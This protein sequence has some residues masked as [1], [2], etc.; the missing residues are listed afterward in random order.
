MAIR[1]YLYLVAATP[2]LFC[3]SAV[4]I[5]T[6]WRSDAPSTNWH[7]PLNWTNGIPSIAGD[8]AT[9]STTGATLR[10]DLGQPASIAV[11]TVAGRGT[12]EISG[13]APLTFSDPSPRTQPSVSLIAQNGD[14][15][16]KIS[17]PLVLPTGEVLTI[18]QAGYSSLWLTGG[19][20]GNGAL[21]FSGRPT[22]YGIT[23]INGNSTYT[24][25]TTIDV[26]TYHTMQAVTSTAFGDDSVGTLIRNGW[27]STP[28]TT[29]PFVVEQFGILLTTTSTT[30]HAGKITLVGG[31]FVPYASNGS[32]NVASNIEIAGRGYVGRSPNASSAALFTGAITGAGTLVVEGSISNQYEFAGGVAVRGDVVL[33]DR[34]NA[35]FTGQFAPRG[36]LSAPGRNGLERARL[37]GD[38]S[39]FSGTVETGLTSLTIGSDLHTPRLRVDARSPEIRESLQRGGILIEAGKTANVDAL[40]F[41]AGSIEGRITGVDAIEKR[42]RGIGAVR[43]LDGFDGQISV[44]QGWLEIEDALGLGT[45]VG[46]TSIARSR[47]A[48]IFLEAGVRVEDALYLN[49]SSGMDYAGSIVGSGELAGN[50]YLGDQGSYVGGSENEASGSVTRTGHLTISGAIH[51]GSLSKMGMNTELR[52]TNQ[53]HTYSG[54]TRI[55]DGKLV[56]TENARLATTASIAVSGDVSNS[57]AD[58]RATL[59][60][61]DRGAVRSNDRLSD[62]VPVYLQSGR[63]ELLGSTAGGSRETI[64]AVHAE[65]GFNR[66]LATAGVIQI[67]EL[68]RSRGAV[69]SFGKPEGGAI[70][71]DAP[72]QNSLIGGWA[73]MAGGHSLMSSDAFATIVDGKVEAA[74]MTRKQLDLAAAHENIELASAMALTGDRTVNS[75]RTVGTVPIAL[76]N[77]TL[78]VESGGFIVNAETTISS[79]R[80]TAGAGS[81]HELFFHLGNNL[82]VAADIVDDGANPV[83]LNVSQKGPATL[84]GVNTYSGGTNVAQDARLTLT[85]RSAIPADDVVNLN[86]GSYLLNFSDTQPVKLNKLAVR[87]RGVVGGT[88]AASIDADLIEAYTGTI[89][90]PLAGDGL[91]VKRGEGTF[92]LEGGSPSFVG[93]VIVEQGTLRMYGTALGGAAPSEASGVFVR[94][95]GVIELNGFNNQ[96]QIVLEGGMIKATGRGDSSLRAP[97]EI[98]QHGDIQGANLTVQSVIR[99]AGTLTLAS[100]ADQLIELLSGFSQFN[101]DVTLTGGKVTLGGSSAGYQGSVFIRASGAS[102][103]H[104]QAFGS[105]VAVVDP[106]GTLAI[107]ASLQSRL[108]LNGGKIVASLNSPTL[109]GA[110]AVTADSV[111]DLPENWFTGSPVVRNMQ[112]SGATTIA[113]DV[114]LKKTSSG[115]LTLNG[116]LHVG[117]GSEIVA[118]EGSVELKGA[119]TAA[120]LGSSLNL[121]GNNN[122]KTGSVSV[123]AGTSLQILNDGV[124]ARLQLNSAAALLAGN[125]TLVGD[126]DVRTGAIVAPG[127]S[128]GTLSIDGDMTIGSGAVYKWELE[129]SN[130]LAGQAGGWDFLDVSSE[131]LFDATP[132]AKWTFKIDPLFASSAVEAPPAGLQT[133]QWLV[134]SSSDLNGFDPAAVVI[135]RSALVAARPQYAIGAFQLNAMGNDLV[136][137][138]AIP[139]PSTL[140]LAGAASVAALAVIRRRQ[141]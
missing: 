88:G 72:L 12:V 130:G 52:I 56:L 107:D 93:Q 132:S 59:V 58:P 6:V 21:A 47:N 117:A 87:S 123:P 29:E 25:L 26:G 16:T 74:P 68:H 37:A 35:L 9:L 109:T 73:T 83:S 46:S 76:N 137:T 15:T 100:G 91:L 96:R 119:I 118:W 20:S 129:N 33:S 65:R 108:Q 122:F 131:L 55:L 27:V 22:N 138:Y 106:E 64:G 67:N 45:T 3:Q 98:R 135:D 42:T 7:D 49:N 81:G 66:I 53:G 103:T 99:G 30:P 85:N 82:N 115:K 14:L 13:N 34:V 95:G 57:N 80:I 8:T 94:D 17:A 10:A 39:Q 90:K 114:R 110:V 71:L 18:S 79:G 128:A 40:E 141:A 77:Y 92:Y 31:A 24:G 50:L 126:V 84:G 136:L 116:P 60:F 63:I 127:A 2:F 101:G 133:R 75:I 139:E 78:K 54:Q 102:V 41:F 86:G 140:V 44:D 125:G 120:Q 48:A 69:V 38:L 113:S 43:R 28:A 105:G 61:N 70:E 104:A 111:I 19:I 1:T 23:Y 5:N 89:S 134:A 112:I 124:A 51:G 121:I 62:A 36:D 4:A 11:L 32:A 97:I